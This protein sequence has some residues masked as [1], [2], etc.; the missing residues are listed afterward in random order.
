M[1]RS[2]AHEA[3]NQALRAGLASPAAAK[4]ASIPT[5][6]LVPGECQKLG[7]HTEVEEVPDSE[8]AR[9]HWIGD[10]SSENVVLYFHGMRPDQDS[11]GMMSM[12][13][14]VLR[15]RH[16]WVNIANTVDRWR[17]WSTTLSRACDIL[18]ANAGE[19]G[20]AW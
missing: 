18:G 13:C 9:I 10:R 14:N 5:K 3:R 12:S 17:I 20:E 15:C 11:C 8:G 4:E 1:S 2:E 16:V 6:D 19:A 7:A